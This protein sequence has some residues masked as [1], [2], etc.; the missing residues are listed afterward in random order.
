MSEQLLY[1]KAMQA[2]RHS[3]RRAALF[4][5]GI[6]LLMLVGPLY[7]L[8][9]YDRVMLSGSIPTLTGL[10]AIVVVL[11]VFL[12][13]YEVMRARVLSR[14]AFAL[15]GTIAA[16]AFARRLEGEEG[17][18]NTLADADFLRGFMAGPAMRALFDA[19]W[20]PIFL[21]TVFLIH[22][23]L[24]VLTLLG[25]GVVVAL[26]LAN[27]HFTRV[28]LLQ[29]A[30][31]DG[32]ERAF[33][34]QCRRGTATIQALGMRA[35]LT[36]R[37]QAMHDASLATGQQGSERGDVFAA[38]SRAFRLLLQAILLTGGAY[39]ALG[40]QI[41]MGMIV[42]VSILAGRALAP[43]DQIIGQWRAIARARETHK[44]LTRTL[45]AGPAAKPALSLPEIKGRVTLAG[46]TKLV[47]G[48]QDKGRPRILDQISLDLAPGDG[49]C[50]MGNSAC[51]KSSLARLLVGAWMP[52]L[53]Q[54]RLDGATLDQWEAD[55]LGRRIG[56]LPQMVELFPGTIAENIARFDP[57][58]DEK[59]IFAAT[60]LARVHEM[61][62]SLPDGYD[63]QVGQ[64]ALPLSGGQAQRIGLARALYGSPKFV[65]LDEPNANLDLA[66]EDALV[67]TVHALRAAGTTVVM[68]SHRPGLIN[69]ANKMMILHKG[70]V[71]QFGDR[72]E[73]MR[74]VNGDRT[75]PAAPEKIV[76]PS[77]RRKTVPLSRIPPKSAP[78]PV[79]TIR[80][81]LPMRTPDRWKTG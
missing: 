73:V 66:G 46:V 67:E 72:D 69:A 16:P 12:A 26:A 43:I 56:Y 2:L 51:G 13:L 27:H 10:F 41:S 55:D 70:R 40:Q 33:V 15:D 20:L 60:R 52:D 31:K 63:T 36:A 18:E 22:P 59:Q 14:A 39:L 79:D 4:S 17:A 11:Y 45:D 77:K 28:P 74:V 19:P 50:V 9:I 75:Q 21:V 53:G 49:L 6:N 48:G 8:Q 58:A 7:M 78:I 68:M 61:I 71:V 25:A 81:A 32:Q 1:S 24:G 34:E 35:A 76:R 30:L 62:L 37:W 57:N 42:G 65:V 80:A 38:A 64:G 54:V 47:P 44:R 3:F 5:V 29:S 23:L